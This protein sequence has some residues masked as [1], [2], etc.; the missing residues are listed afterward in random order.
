MCNGLLLSYLTFLVK[1]LLDICQCQDN[2][3]CVPI[4]CLEGSVVPDLDILAKGIP[5]CFHV[6]YRLLR[7]GA[8]GDEIVRAAGHGLAL[9][10][11]QGGG[12][13]GRSERG[14]LIRLVSSGRMTREEAIR[15]S[16]ELMLAEGGSRHAHIAHNAM[17]QIVAGAGSA[18]FEGA[19]QGCGALVVAFCHGFVDNLLLGRAGP[20][21]MV[22]LYPGAVLCDAAEVRMHLAL[23]PTIRV[24]AAQLALDPSGKAVQAPRTPRAARQ[25][26]AEILGE[27]VG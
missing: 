8:P 5:S 7:G 6:S 9:A 10:I 23:E 3:R 25:S 2:I 24:L 27:V 13:P 20:D 26:T 16:R 17:S 14:E 19:D 11:R 12:V 18:A 15:R 22:T 21:F 1:M 4:N